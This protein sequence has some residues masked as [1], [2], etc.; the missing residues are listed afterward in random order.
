MRCRDSMGSTHCSQT[1]TVQYHLLLLRQTV[2]LPQ[3]KQAQL[4]YLDN[5]IGEKKSH[6]EITDYS[7]DVI[8]SLYS[9]H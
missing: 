3:Q 4:S 8:I 2:F 6:K 5:F 7:L 9:L 1:V